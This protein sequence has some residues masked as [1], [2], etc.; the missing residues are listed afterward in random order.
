MMLPFPDCPL[1]QQLGLGQVRV[2]C[3]LRFIH[4]CCQKTIRKSSWNHVLRGCWTVGESQQHFPEEA[5]EFDDDSHLRRIIDS[6]VSRV[7]R[8]I[9]ESSPMVD[10]RLH[11]GSRVNAIIP[12]L[13][14]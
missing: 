4:V 13:S 14:L 2:D 9:D 3:L 7:G 6:I 11:D 1:K 5:P 8:R 12:P 10:A